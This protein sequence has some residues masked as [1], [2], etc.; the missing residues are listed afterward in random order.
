LADFFTNHCARIS[1]PI[2]EPP[3]VVTRYAELVRGIKASIDQR[4]IDVCNALTPHLLGGEM[5]INRG[6]RVQVDRRDRLLMHLIQT[7]CASG[8]RACE[9]SGSRI[10]PPQLDEFFS[11]ARAPLIASMAFASLG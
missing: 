9:P 11:I 1:D 3:K 2:H 5:R 7:K 10:K 8:T 4:F 6:T